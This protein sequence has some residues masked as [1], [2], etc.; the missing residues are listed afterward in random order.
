MFLWKRGF[1]EGPC[2]QGPVSVFFWDLTPGLCEVIHLG[3]EQDTRFFFI[4]WTL[5]FKGQLKAHRKEAGLW[6]EAMK[7][8][9]S[10]ELA[11]LFAFFVVMAMHWRIQSGQWFQRI[12]IIEGGREEEER[13][14]W[15]TL[16]QH[17]HLLTNLGYI[18]VFSLFLCHRKHKSTTFLS[19]TGGVVT[20]HTSYQPL[21]SQQTLRFPSKVKGSAS[22]DCSHWGYQTLI[23]FCLSH[24]LI[25]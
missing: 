12:L 25:L 21:L 14:G 1:W 2:C 13:G 20:C 5:F 24:L 17:L 3:Y 8:S 18:L 15:T 10:S 7:P 11:T 4:T 22:K 6:R 16:C 9:W 19:I 23:G